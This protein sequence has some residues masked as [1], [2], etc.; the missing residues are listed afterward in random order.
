MATKRVTASTKKVV[1]GM[2]VLLA[3]AKE[4]LSSNSQGIKQDVR[5]II[6]AA[7]AKRRG[8]GK[9][10][11]TAALLDLSVNP[12]AG[13]E[14][15]T[16]NKEEWAAIHKQTE[17]TFQATMKLDKELHSIQ[18]SLSHSHVI[19][20]NCCAEFGSLPDVVKA[21]ETA[22]EQVVG[23]GELLRQVEESVMEYC[24]VTAR[25]ESERKRSS[26]KIQSDKH[27]AVSD[28][29]RRKFEGVLAEE[30]RLTLATEEEI[31]SQKIQERQQA[32]QEIFDQQMAEYKSRGEVER[33]IGVDSRERSDSQL[34]DVI[35][36]DK[37]GTDSL[38]EFLGDVVV[39]GGDEPPDQAVE[40]HDQSEKPPDQ[41]VESHDQSEKPPDRAVESHDQSEKPPDRAVESHDQSEKPPDRAVESHDQSE[42][43]PDRAVESHDQSEKPPDRAVESPDQAVESPDS[44]AGEEDIFHECT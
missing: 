29:E 8:G 44:Q 17:E 18:T 42:K 5:E 38:N 24:R 14:I 23:I 1:D 26:L 7:Q 39:N 40:S 37:E 3:L 9:R 25:L 10:P 13:A 35:I 22:K 41:A 15:L 6:E 34:E 20:T 30:K 12:D 19:I 28:S 4:D 36:E 11:K 32:F 31:A 16:H 21:V 43:P 27:K 33:P 2:K